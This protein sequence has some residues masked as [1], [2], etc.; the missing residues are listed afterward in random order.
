MQPDVDPHEYG[1]PRVAIIDD[2]FPSSVILPPNEQRLVR[3]NESLL[4]IVTVD[5]DRSTRVKLVVLASA[6]EELL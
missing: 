4:G 2:D 5:D 3:A 6:K 1:F